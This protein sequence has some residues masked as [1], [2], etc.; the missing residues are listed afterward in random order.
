MLPICGPCWLPI[1]SFLF[2]AALL[3]TLALLPSSRHANL[4]RIGFRRNVVP[5]WIPN[6]PCNLIILKFHAMQ[7]FV[8]WIVFFLIFGLHTLIVNVYF[9]QCRSVDHRYETLANL[10]YVWLWQTHLTRV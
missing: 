2:I 9:A 7:A 1:V 3:P 8:L 6:K 4:D 5:K 10:R